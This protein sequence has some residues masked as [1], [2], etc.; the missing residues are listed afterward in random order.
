ML[1][2]GALSFINSL[3]FFQPFIEK[4]VPYDGHFSYGSPTEINTLLEKGSIDIG[5]ISSA[6]FLA[7]RERYILLTNLG[8]G[9]QR[10]VMSVCLYSKVPLDQLTNKSIAIPSVSATSVMLLKVL[11]KYF[12][13]VSPHFIE[14]PKEAEPTALFHNF[15]AVLLIGDTCLTTKIE[16]NVLTVDLA[17]AWYQHTGKPFIFAVFATRCDIWM[18]E[19]ELVRD[20]HKR[21]FTSYEYSQSH[22]SEILTRAQEK[23]NLSLNTVTEYYKSIDYYLEAEHFQGLEHFA[24]LKNDQK[25]LQGLP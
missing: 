6:S 16:S 18:Q 17:E 19:P 23:T 25:V 24:R 13:N 2:I 4:K 7:N 8:I 22:F 11:C 20:F 5:L 1:K 3:P 10:R 14:Y 12:W 15:D 9:A 21:L